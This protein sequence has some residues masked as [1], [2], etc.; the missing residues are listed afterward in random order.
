M[1]CASMTCTLKM[2]LRLCPGVETPGL[3]SVSSSATV[4]PEHGVTMLRSLLL[5]CMMLS[6]VACCCQV[7]LFESSLPVSS[8]LNRQK[9]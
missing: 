8:V 2:L 7:L 9:L 1:A 5:D 6:S 4:T 3:K